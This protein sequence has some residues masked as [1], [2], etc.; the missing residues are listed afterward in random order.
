MYLGTLT[1]YTEQLRRHGVTPRGVDWS[2]SD[3]QEQRFEQLLKLCDFSRGFALNDIGCGY[4]ALL[5]YLGKRHPGVRINY[6]GVDLSPAMIRE[7]VRLWGGRDDTAFAVGNG[8]QRSADYSVASGIFNVRQRER[9]EAWERLVAYTLDQLRA[10]SRRGFAVNF[11]AAGA[12]DA[13]RPGLYAT[14]PQPWINHCER[15]LGWSA[16]L[17]MGYALPEFTLLVRPRS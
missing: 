11:K 17:V 6:L 13:R 15:E 8:A 10:T 1:Y 16:E 3:E 5:G 7:A 4:G 12:P 9:R 2:D 14:E